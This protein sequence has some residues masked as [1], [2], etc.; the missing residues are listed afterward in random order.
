[1]PPDSVGWPGLTQE[2]VTKVTSEDDGFPGYNGPID[3][4]KALQSLED[5]IRP[6]AVNKEV[7]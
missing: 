2:W 6:D 7:D 4:E 1:M 3:V 5:A